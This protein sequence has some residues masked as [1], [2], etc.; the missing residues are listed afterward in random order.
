MTN[1]LQQEKLCQISQQGMRQAAQMLSRLLRQNIEVEVANVLLSDC[2][3]VLDAEAEQQLGI[4]LQVTGEVNGGM[5]LTFSKECAAWLC[6]RLLGT[7][8]DNLLV[9]PASSTLREVGNIMASS[10]LA[11]IDE[12][13]G[14]RA[15][16]SPP[17]LHCAPLKE[18]LQRC[19]LASGEDCLIVQ[20]RLLGEAG[21]DGRL[22]GTIYL[23]PQTVALEKLREQID[24]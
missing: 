20:T 8:S 12:Q 9:E 23:L 14:L 6:G 5:L 1:N 7:T 19:Q 16:P 3:K 24:G 21:A 15:L 11:S 13:L 22:Q 18:L 17:Q 10:F 4:Y 2:K